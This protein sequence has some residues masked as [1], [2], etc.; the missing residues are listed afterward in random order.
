M[1]RA[2]QIAKVARHLYASAQAQREQCRCR[3]L[4]FDDAPSTTQ[5][6][7][8]RLACDVVDRWSL[9]ERLEMSA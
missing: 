8:V 2:Q 4:S 3:I 9:V 5:S 7:Y 1:D 6:F